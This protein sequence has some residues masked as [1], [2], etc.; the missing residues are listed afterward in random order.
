MKIEIDK[1][2]D[3]TYIYFKE[4]SPGEV[5]QTISLNE[6]I[7]IDLDSE[8]KTLGIEVLN[9]S[10]NLPSAALKSVKIADAN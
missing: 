9:A 2:A 10:K 5:V 8:G 3:A 1:E 7:N 6:S 4:I